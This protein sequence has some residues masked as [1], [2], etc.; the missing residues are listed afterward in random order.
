MVNEKD[1]ANKMDVEEKIYEELQ[2]LGEVLKGL[3]GIR[4]RNAT[5]EKEV[6]LLSTHQKQTDGSIKELQ[7]KIVEIQRNIDQIVLNQKNQSYSNHSNDNLRAISGLN[8]R[9]D[10][11]Q[12][13]LN[14]IQ[15]EF[16]MQKFDVDKMR[17]MFDGHDKSLQSL[18]GEVQRV[19]D[20]YFSLKYG[21][22]LLDRR[23]IGLENRLIEISANYTALE[24]NLKGSKVF[25][26]RK[27][28]V[29]I[30]T[31][32]ALIILL[33]LALYAK[34][35]YRIDVFGSLLPLYL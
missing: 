24:K 4:I 15:H 14:N 12:R 33:I 16:N 25:R 9:I 3:E 22:G 17:S 30:F 35:Y 31:L 6:A 34:V 27:F 19:D 7:D 28:H 29:A 23:I 20:K 32:F 8:S 26:G 21:N 10:K 13:D 11:F 5:V 2:R 1:I 18:K